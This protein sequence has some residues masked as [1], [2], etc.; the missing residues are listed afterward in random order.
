MSE[1]PPAPAREP[2]TAP[3]TSVSPLPLTAGLSLLCL[4]GVLAILGDIG[5]ASLSV[6]L[7]AG[8]LL[9][10]AAGDRRPHIMRLG[11]AC[12]ALAGVASF[13]HILLRVLGP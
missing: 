8:I 5:L 2:E 6:L 7:A 4:S 1:P 9:V 12:T 13:V 3:M 10:G 11:V